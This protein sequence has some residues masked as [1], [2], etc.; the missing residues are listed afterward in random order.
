[1]LDDFYEQGWCKVCSK[2][3]S[4]EWKRRNK[5]SV[6]KTNKNVKD[7]YIELNK[8]RDPYLSELI[9]KPCSKC[10]C[11]LPLTE[12]YRNKRQK[13]GLNSY[14]KLC[15]KKRVAERRGHTLDIDSDTY[16]ALVKKQNGL[17]A[18]CDRP[19]KLAIDHC[20]TT[21][22][23]RGLLC[24]SCN[25]SLGKFEDNIEWLQSA[26]RYLSVVQDA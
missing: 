9:E 25:T 7:R 8:G 24:F 20:H 15:D 26:V 11:I 17:C 16:Y 2:Q 18:I 4:R 10:K 13:D 3:Y 12:F 1:M 19:G 21:N 23:V 22:I 5:D 6:A 14:C